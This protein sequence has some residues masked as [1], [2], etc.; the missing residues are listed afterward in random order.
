[1]TSPPGGR[2]GRRLA[3]VLLVVGH[4]AAA[5]RQAAANQERSA[6]MKSEDDAIE[7]R[8]Q[9]VVR[10][11][12][13]DVTITLADA[14]AMRDAL[15]TYLQGA[16]YEDRDALLERTQGSAWIDAEGTVRIGVW[17][18]GAEDDELYLR[19]REAAG[20]LA[21]KAHRATLQKKDGAWTVTALETERI[22][23]RR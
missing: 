20:Q 21:A 2:T 8:P 15:R 7:S 18:L 19:Y 1:V 14:R 9:T 17:V 22:R 5:G 16:E 3:A 6:T 4:A 10:V 12:D 23:V 13:A 11:G